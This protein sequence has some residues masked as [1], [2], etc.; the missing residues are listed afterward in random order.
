MPPI[1]HQRLVPVSDG[2]AVGAAVGAGVVG[3]DVAA[4]GAEAAGAVALLPGLYVM[5]C[6]V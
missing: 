6:D 4:F 2:V 3:A 5:A 1:I